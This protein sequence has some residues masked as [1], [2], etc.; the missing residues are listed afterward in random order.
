[1]KPN[2]KDI[3]ND[4]YDIPRQSTT[5][6]KSR[7]NFSNK[8]SI[9]ILNRQLEESSKELFETQR[10]SQINQDSVGRTIGTSGSNMTRNNVSSTLQLPNM[11][12]N[13]SNIKS[14]F[15]QA[16]ESLQPTPYPYLSHQT[17]AENL[18]NTLSYTNNYIKIPT[19]KKKLKIKTSNKVSPKSSK[20]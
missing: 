13:D 2:L 4:S 9:R 7:S 10:K 16:R 17:S 11:P 6:Q 3:M 19:K 1:M 20:I 14:K 15:F 8:N 12:S 18:S 5:I